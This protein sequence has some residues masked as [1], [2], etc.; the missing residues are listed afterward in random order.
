MREI[1]KLLCSGDGK[2]PCQGGAMYSTTKNKK[3]S[4]KKL[5]LR[6]F[7]KMCKKHTIHKEGK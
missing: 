6:K 7:C 5:E 4:T 1:I 3:A 2:I